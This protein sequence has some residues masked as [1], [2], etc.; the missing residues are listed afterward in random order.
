MAIDDGHQNFKSEKLEKTD[1]DK[2]QKSESDR[3]PP[4]SPSLNAAS[5]VTDA[6]RS[7]YQ[8]AFNSLTA[9]SAKVDSL[10]LEV[11]LRLQFFLSLYLFTFLSLSIRRTS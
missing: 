7:V 10:G 5:G 9:W 4:P 3:V 1:A 11:S 6:Q 8:N 2:V